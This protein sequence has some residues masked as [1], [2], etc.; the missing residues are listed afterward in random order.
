MNEKPFSQGNPNFYRALLEAL[1]IPIYY[2]DAEGRY[3]GCNAAFERLI[4]LSCECLIGK[5]AREI[6]PQGEAAI[7]GAVDRELLST[8]GVQ[9]YEYAF[10]NAEGTYYTVMLHKSAI[11]DPP[12]VIVGAAIDVTDRKQFEE[13]LLRSENL[14]RS[15]IEASYDGIAIT[16][17]TGTVIEWNDAQAHIMGIQREDA[18][19]HKIWDLQYEVA[20]EERKSPQ[21]YAALKSALSAVYDGAGAQMLNTIRETT[22]QRPDGTR[23]A[24]EAVAF[25]IHTENGIMVGS[26]MRD[27]TTAKRA[28]EELQAELAI[29][30]ALAA[31]YRPLI[32]PDSTMAFIAESV[33]EQAQ[34]LTGSDHGYVGSI[35]PR[36]GFLICHT[37]TF[38]FGEER[39]HVTG[40]DQRV[41]FPPLPDG[42]YPALWG[43]SLN[44]RSPFF[45]NDPVAHPASKGIP[46]GHIAMQNFLSVP[47]L[48]GDELVGQ[49]ALANRPDGYTMR[50]LDMARRFGELYAFAVQRKLSEE[51][52]RARTQALQT[53]HDVTL[54]MNLEL[55][56]HALLARIVESAANALNAD[57]GARIFLYDEE[58]DLLRVS[59]NY[60][61]SDET[62]PLIKPGKGVV[63]YA[64]AQ[65]RTV[66]VHDYDHWE[67]RLPQKP[68][69][70]N[71]T[72]I[73]SPL[74]WQGRIL[75]VLALRADRSQH[76]FN[77]EDAQ[78]L[79]MFAA[80]AAS[81]LQNARLHRQ[82]VE[83]TQALR[84]LHEIAIDINSRLEKPDLLHRILERALEL[85][86]AD[87]G[88]SIMIYDP[89]DGLL[90][91][92]ESYAPDLEK[93]RPFSMKPGQGLAGRVFAQQKPLF[94]NGYHEWEGKNP[95]YEE[96]PPKN[97]LGVPLILAGEPFGVLIISALR[98]TRTFDTSDL[99]VAEMFAAQVAV[100][101]QNARLHAESTRRTAALQTLYDV[102]LDLAGDL[103]RETL[104][105]RIVARATRLLDTECRATLALYVPEDGLLHVVRNS[106]HPIENLP[107]TTFA[108]GEGATGRA[109]Q[110]RQ[111]LIIQDYNN[112]TGHLPGFA[113]A[114]SLDVLAVP[115]IWQGRAKGV[116]LLRAECGTAF[117]TEAIHVVEMF[118]TQ[119]AAALENADLLEER[120][121]HAERLEE[122]V[123]ERTAEIRRQ[124]EQTRSILENI[125]DAIVIADG[126]GI[127]VDL[128]RA[129]TELFKI[130]D[131][132]NFFGL[133]IFEMLASRLSPEAF[134]NL[135]EIIRTGQNWKGEIVVNIADGTLIETAVTFVPILNPEGEIENIIGS[136][137][138]IGAFKQLD[139]MKSS[140]MRHI[141]HELRTPLSNINLY[142]HMLKSGKK[143]ERADYFLD[144]IM[145]QSQRLIRM[146]EKV[147]DV[148]RL[149]DEN[150]LGTPQDVPA[151]MLLEEV[152][153]R[154][155]PVAERRGIILKTEPSSENAI[156]TGYAYWLSRALGELV[157]NALT[158]TIETGVSHEQPC[159]GSC[160]VSV[161]VRVLNDRPNPQVAMDV[162]DNGPGIPEDHLKQIMAMTF[163]RGEIGETG[164]VP[165]TG[166]GLTIAQMVAERH[167]GTLRVT[168]E[169]DG[170]TT[171]TMLLPLSKPDAAP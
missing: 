151:Q 58:N 77:Q 44:T 116:L 18:L 37:F 169:K 28:E 150:N 107:K 76:R 139:R 66:I 126:E 25:P 38:M 20:S 65:R 137:T 124:N 39:C 149:T 113:E 23:C 72:L 117:D 68:E 89:E 86:E 60:N 104:L 51:A 40:P 6:M 97:L 1:P 130:E 133:D 48:F 98:E 64:F 81:T 171:I 132:S 19:G 43:C 32:S 121:Q 12:T 166:L 9:A 95:E 157:E 70:A 47:V 56:L 87:R 91:S 119:A 127:I 29:N 123:R 102:T 152:L 33:L 21:A 11:G 134:E 161:G 36:T 24:V 114:P 46:K 53:L 31:L 122:E 170:G 10:E 14:F 115:L 34:S 80:Q 165:G 93:P 59:Q 49:I 144:T 27:V 26:I 83:Q 41:V 160:Q 90:H 143:P 163:Y 85:F 75:G 96:G 78:L 54:G 141:S 109:F 147:L 84:T 112:W 57:N 71:L 156:V 35:D 61:A 128:N 50:D 17:E 159:G 67:N 63:G 100:A 69:I 125:A 111:T 99:R 92:A 142:T 146:S 120:Q 94:I 5:T 131:K 73:A 129:C 82:I 164:S 16:D 118:A 145:A 13:N 110:N 55:D 135:R 74:V 168:S 42:T 7:Q 22:L 103:G 108:P 30:E 3:M 15:V 154:F 153:T 138:D 162:R 158:F 8:P 4:G 2:K 148:V 52:L 106:P 79:E 88:A 140:F 155:R 45:T 167:G 62:L 105:D 101:I 136:M